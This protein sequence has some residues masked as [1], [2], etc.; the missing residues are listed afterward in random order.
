M[1]A[2]THGPCLVSFRLPINFTAWFKTSDAE[3]IGRA[4]G[5]LDAPTDLDPG[6]VDRALDDLTPLA[7]RIADV[8]L[9]RYRSGLVGRRLSR[10][11]LLL[12]IDTVEGYLRRCAE[13]DDE[14]R[15]L[16][17]ELFINVTAFFRDP[18]TF[19]ALRRTLE[20][21]EAAHD[22]RAWSAGCAS[23]EEA[24]S[25][26]MLLH[27]LLERDGARSVDYQ[28]FGTDLNP[29]AIARARAERVPKKY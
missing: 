19:S 21:R 22:V 11:M 5:R 12:G 29:G 6:D 1:T 28:V 8:D 17:Q 15:A 16:V 10:R 23:G 24:Y 27:D 2:K 4:I 18:A 9:R 26:A 3:D 14:V 13:D 7:A 20:E 25:T